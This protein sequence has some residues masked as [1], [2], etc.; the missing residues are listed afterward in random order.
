MDAMGAM[1]RGVPRILEELVDGRLTDGEADAVVDWLTTA[2]LED[3]P[4]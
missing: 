2:G 4:P 1:R 3:P